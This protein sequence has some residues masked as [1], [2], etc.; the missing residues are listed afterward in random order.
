MCKRI[1]TLAAL[2]LVA[3]AVVASASASAA[4]VSAGDVY[5]RDYKK[6]YVI[7]TAYKGDTMD[8]DLQSNGWAL[9][10]VT[11]SYYRGCGWVLVTALDPGDAPSHSSCVDRVQGSKTRLA[12]PT[13]GEQTGTSSNGYPQI[14]V[15]RQSDAC[16]GGSAKTGLYGNYVDGR[17]RNRRDYSI[18][19]ASGTYVAFRYTST[20]GR[21][22]VVRRP[23]V[24]GG[25]WFFMRRDCITVPAFTR[26]S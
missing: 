10:Y 23:R 20:D 13:N 17:F 12:L 24:D 4:K 8:I 9:G 14:V 15:A 16:P 6:A 21:A 7:G 5:I 2:T 22:A 25:G 19:K 18:A 1:V 11:S 26:V 3:T